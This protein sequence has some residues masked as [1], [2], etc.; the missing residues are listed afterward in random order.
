MDTTSCLC[1]YAFLH[2]GNFLPPISKNLLWVSETD[3]CGVGWGVE[4]TATGRDGAGKATLHFLKLS[5]LPSDTT[6]E[7]IL[8]SG[9]LTT[10]KS[11]AKPAFTF[12]SGIQCKLE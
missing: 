5:I 10:I 2:F 9:L 8:N 1:M 4:E 12:F 6:L 7:A 3:V 11:T